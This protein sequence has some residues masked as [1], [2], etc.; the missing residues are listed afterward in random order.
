MYF[1]N[2]WYK[3]SRLV[4]PMEVNASIAKVDIVKFDETSNFRLW[5]RRVKDL[6][7]HKGLVKALNGKTKKPEKMIDDE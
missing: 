2:N 3:S 5:Q 4:D 7:V 1:H 6:M